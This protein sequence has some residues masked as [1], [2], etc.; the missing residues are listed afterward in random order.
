ML[1]FVRGR[2]LRDICQICGG[3][4]GEQHGIE[5]SIRVSLWGWNACLMASSEADTK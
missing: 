5:E 2:L 4:K 1:S 3:E